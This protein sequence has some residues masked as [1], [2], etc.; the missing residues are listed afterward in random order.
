M[1][2]LM[3]HM[4]VHHKPNRYF[5]CATCKVRF[6]K[7]QTFFKHRQV[8]NDETNSLLQNVKKQC[9]S[10]LPANESD[11]QVKQSALTEPVKFQSV[12]RQLEKTGNM[13]VSSAAAP[14][15]NPVSLLPSTLPSLHTS[16]NSMPL[17]ST[18]P[19]PFSLLDPTLFAT[20]SLRFSTPGH[21]P[22]PGPFIPYIHSAPYSLSQSATQS[23]LRSCVPSEG[24]PLSNA[25]WRKTTAQSANSRIVWEHTRGQYNCLQCPYFTE[26][27]EEMTL[28]IQEHSKVL[29]SRLPNEMGMFI[30]PG[31][32][33]SPLSMQFSE[34]L[35]T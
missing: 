2:H 1:Q 22:V 5:K 23:H 24:L 17:V 3:N 9:P 15:S 29:S 33:L 19:H 25:V 32:N 13:D 34:S 35:L 21:T 31:D 16:L 10:P 14:S 30:N 26:S 11:V 18:T 28:H 27:R 12:I 8:C 4:K 7:P 6:Q 20:P